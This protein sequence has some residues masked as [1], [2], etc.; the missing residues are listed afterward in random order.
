M[1]NPHMLVP[2]PPSDFRTLG[3]TSF[4][5]VRLWTD[6]HHDEPAARSV[7]DVLQ[8]LPADDVLEVLRGYE[9][10]ARAHFAAREAGSGS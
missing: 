5:A 3:E 10:A 2:D 8:G 1:S 9:A 4:G 7:A 6:A